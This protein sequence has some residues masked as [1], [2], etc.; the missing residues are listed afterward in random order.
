MHHS[1]SSY[2]SSYDD[3]PVLAGLVAE[4]ALD[5]SRTECDPYFTVASSGSV[6]GLWG[7]WQCY[8]DGATSATEQQGASSFGGTV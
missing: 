8:W 4:V 7:G 3:W 1:K 5:T 2:R 6:R